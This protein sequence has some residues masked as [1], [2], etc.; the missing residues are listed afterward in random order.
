MK[1][2][3]LYTKIKK[4][5][6]YLGNG[7][8]GIKKVKGHTLLKRNPERLLH[9]DLS[10]VFQP[11]LSLG[12]L[13]HIGRHSSSSS[14]SSSSPSPSPSPFSSFFPFSEESS[15]PVNFQ[16]WAKNKLLLY[17]TEIVGLFLTAV[18]LYPEWYRTTKNLFAILMWIKQSLPVNDDMTFRK[19]KLLMIVLYLKINLEYPGLWKYGMY[20][21][22]MWCLHGMLESR[23]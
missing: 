2:Y 21:M 1:C 16:V 7:G 8:Q 17:C 14:S 13:E 23:S 9:H 4:Q 3:S 11:G 10:L 18:K 12:R 22:R 20:F 6:G 15:P 19:Y 5:N